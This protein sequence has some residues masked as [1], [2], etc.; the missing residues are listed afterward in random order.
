[1]IKTQGM[2]HFTIPITD[3]EKSAGFYSELL[4]TRI[5]QKTPVFVFLKWG[6]DYLVLGKEKTQ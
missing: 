5:L 3:L 4:G 2:V 1:M 6:N